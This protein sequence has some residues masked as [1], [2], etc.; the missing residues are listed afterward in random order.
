[1]LYHQHVAHVYTKPFVLMNIDYHL[2]QVTKLQHRLF[3][4]L[5]LLMLNLVQELEC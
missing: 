2:L 4:F 3:Y 1:M 5:I